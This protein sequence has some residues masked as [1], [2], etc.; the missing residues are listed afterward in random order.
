MNFF[1]YIKNFFFILIILQLAP[2]LIEGVRKQYSAYLQPKAKVGL[3]SCK[4]TLYDATPYVKQ[5]NTFF[6]DD[7]IKGI[8]IKMECQG[9]A[10]GTGQTIHNELKTLKNIHQ[11][12]VVVIV[13]NICTSGGYY[14]ASVADHIVAPGMAIIGS[15]GTCLPYLFQLREFIEKYNIKYV[16][17]KSGTY[18]SMSD[19]FI[20]LDEQGKKQLQGV[21]D[22]S[23]QQFV[24]DVAENRHLARAQASVWADGKIFS[25]KQA[26]ELGLIDSLGSMYDA[27]EI[28]KKNALI[29]DEIELVQEAPASAWLSWFD[30]SSDQ[31]TNV[32]FS[33]HMLK[34][35]AAY[36]TTKYTT[37]PHC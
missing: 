4:G 22:D 29:D 16:P 36:C 12:P 35:F 30:S 25:G 11:K 31:E 21:L 23:Y 18:K 6:K 10:S 14:I 37:V 17:M 24:C 27:L 15:I 26:L 2:V 19:P 33:Q 1:D 5:L 13:E 34:S 3:I 32:S 28:M 7:S 8:L 9:S 20:D